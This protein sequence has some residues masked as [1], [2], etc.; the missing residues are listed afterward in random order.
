MSR[1]GDLN[2]RPTV[3]EITIDPIHL[4]PLS[5]LN[6]NS[7]NLDDHVSISKSTYGF[8]FDEVREENDPDRGKMREAFFP[9]VKEA[10]EHLDRG[11]VGSARA[12]LAS[13]LDEGD[14]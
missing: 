7:D 1:F 8:K 6:S 4:A 9:R 11:D 10:L 12:L 2:P 14:S 3:Y 5:N 13:I